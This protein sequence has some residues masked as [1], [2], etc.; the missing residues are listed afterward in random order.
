MPAAPYV[1]QREGHCIQ[2]IIGQRFAN[3]TDSFECLPEHHP[4]GNQKFSHRVHIHFPQE[5]DVPTCK[6][7][8]LSK[9]IKQE[10][11]R[12]KKLR[13]VCFNNGANRAQSFAIHSSQ[14]CDLSERTKREEN[15]LVRHTVNREKKACAPSE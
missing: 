11:T 13:T 2:T 8:C 12:E 9:Q 3:N 5:H 15:S 4:R 7:K 14:A 10:E 6:A 1:W